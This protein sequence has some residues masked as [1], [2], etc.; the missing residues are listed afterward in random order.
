MASPPGGHVSRPT[1][2]AFAV[3]VAGVVGYEAEAIAAAARRC[4]GSRAPPGRLPR[5]AVEDDERPIA[6]S[7]VVA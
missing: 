7:T 4:V 3:V 2:A 6:A 1:W 5:N